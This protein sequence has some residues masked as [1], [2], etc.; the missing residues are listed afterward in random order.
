[1]GIKEFCDK[2]NKLLYSLARCYGEYPIYHYTSLEGMHGI[3]SNSTIRFTNRFCLNDR[4]EG[5]YVFT[6]LENNIDKIIPRDHPLHKLKDDIKD[7]AREHS[8]KLP[9]NSSCVY[10]A[11]F[12]LDGDSLCLWNYYTKGD[13]IEGYNLGLNPK[14]IQKSIRKYL[15]KK[16]KKPYVLCHKVIYN[17]EKQINMLRKWLLGMYDAI[18][19]EVK[20]DNQVCRNR[21]GLKME[22]YIF[23]RIATLG[24]FFKDP[25]FSIENEYRLS[26]D[27]V[28]DY[29]SVNDKII[30]YG[31]DTERQSLCKK[32]MIVPYYDFKF[33]LSAIKSITASP[34][35]DTN[36]TLKNMKVFFKNKGMEQVDFSKSKIP[37]RF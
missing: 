9:E 15:S 28:C 18:E 5:F 14:E 6:L 21:H 19:G 25:C 11:S 23:G 20:E 30:T 24:A 22:E 16:R 17:E 2:S 37:V 12:S 27:L 33:D 13:N 8:E 34:T 1:M 29:D 31:V 32:G 10:Q 26:I 36:D 35:I 7:K 3:I 4:S